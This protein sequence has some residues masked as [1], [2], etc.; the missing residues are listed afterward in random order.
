MFIWYFDNAIKGAAGVIHTKLVI[1]TDNVDIY[2]SKII[3]GGEILKQENNFRFYLIILII[4]DIL[5]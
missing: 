2:N 1:K 4:A 3:N 5:I